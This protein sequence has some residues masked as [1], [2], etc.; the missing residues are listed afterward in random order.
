MYLQCIYVCHKSAEDE[1]EEE[2]KAAP[3][4]IYLIGH[5]NIL[6]EKMENE[7]GISA[8]TLYVYHIYGM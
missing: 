4:L 5:E 1:E 8:L 2:E 3:V 6:L 7:T